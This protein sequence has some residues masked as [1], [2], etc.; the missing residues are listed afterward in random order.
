MS[1]KTLQKRIALVAVAAMGFGLVATVPA[2]A[3]VSAI[4]VALASDR[5]DTALTL[6]A[7]TSSAT[8]ATA[9][10]DPTVVYSQN[11]TIAL[12]DLTIATTGG[13]AANSTMG[14]IASDA[15]GTITE[16]TSDANVRWGA[17]RTTNALSATALGT[18]TATTIGAS[19][20]TSI[21][22]SADAP[23]RSPVRKP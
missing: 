7:G 21:T 16:G 23:P 11:S 3:A 19:A 9:L 14:F 8:K 20:P 1:I 10:A 2:N 17:D 18:A 5:T 4:T 12:N 6:T 15:S 13:G 22:A